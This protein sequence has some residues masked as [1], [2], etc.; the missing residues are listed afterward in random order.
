MGSPLSTVREAIKQTQADRVQA[1]ERLQMLEKMIKGHLREAKTHILNG[2]R[3][4]QEIHS[5]TIV[6][7]FTEVSIKTDSAPNK[8]EEIVNAF[9]SGDWKTGLKTII[10]GAVSAIAEN[11][12][13][14]EHEQQTMFITWED[15]ALIRSDLYIYRW[16]FSA[17]GVIDTYEGVC[18][19]LMMKRVVDVLNVDIQ[20]LTW[21]ISCSNPSQE[22]QNEE[23]RDAMDMIV[24]VANLKK[25]I[26]STTIKPEVLPIEDSTP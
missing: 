18:G 17:K 21:A 7:E 26:A 13:A 9:F 16:N 4:D 6:Q 14:G 23:I 3:G 19:I 12:S 25:M 15:N 24:K 8:A 10:L 22:K 20:V 5:G 1:E 2:E 11:I